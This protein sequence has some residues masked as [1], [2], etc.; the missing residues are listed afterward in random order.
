MASTAFVFPGQ[1]SQS[2]GMLADVG[3]RPLVAESYAEASERLGY[4]LWKLTQEGP[5][6]QLTQTEFTQPAILTASVALW[7]LAREGGVSVG[8]SVAALPLSQASQLP[9]WTF[10]APRQRASHGYR[11]EFRPGGSDSACNPGCA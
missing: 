1:G 2:V 4:D 7:R 11:C 8:A 3:D 9:H 5:E 10:V 6:E